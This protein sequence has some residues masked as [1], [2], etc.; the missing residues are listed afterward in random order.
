MFL[1]WF[2]WIG[3]ALAGPAEPLARVG[4]A[5]RVKT[6]ATVTETAPPR[7]YRRS[8][9]GRFKVWTWSDGT[10]EHFE[11]REGRELIRV[12]R[13]H[14][15][16]SP[17]TTLLFE[18]GK[19]SRVIVHGVRP[20]EHDLTSWVPWT[21]GHLTLLLPTSPNSENKLQIPQGEVSFAVTERVEMFDSALEKSIRNSCACVVEDRNPIWVDGKV[22]VRFRLAYPHPKAPKTGELWVLPVGKLQTLY[23]AATVEEVTSGPGALSIARTIVSLLELEPSS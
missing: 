3:V 12:Q 21:L 5:L 7:A 6:Y 9:R 2:L 17:I 15:S 14:A 19:P 1:W 8:R 18:Q 4:E 20:V 10:I 13:F 16:G 22:G 23:I 11:E